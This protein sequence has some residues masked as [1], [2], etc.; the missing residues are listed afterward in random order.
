MLRVCVRAWRHAA[1]HAAHVGGVGDQVRRVYNATW[2]T[3]A[4]T[5]QVVVKVVNKEQGAHEK[6][7]LSALAH[8]PRAHAIR[9]LG[10]VRV[11]DTDVGLITPA[12][13][14]QLF[15]GATA[16]Q[17]E[18]QAIQLC[19]VSSAPP[20]RLLQQVSHVRDSRDLLCLSV[21][22]RACVCVCV[23]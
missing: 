5:Q 19:K 12:C 14:R 6:S 11:G 7:I 20:A 9:L 1:P 3:G 4:G 21:C 23:W 2:S 17:V 18:R 13:P 16:P 15:V 8:N 10:E 22:V